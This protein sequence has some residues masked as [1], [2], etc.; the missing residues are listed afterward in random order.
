[1][2]SWIIS[3]IADYFLILKMHIKPLINYVQEPTKIRSITTPLVKNAR[4]LE[5]EWTCKLQTPP[6]SIHN[7]LLIHPI[8]W[9]Y[10]THSSW[11]A[12][13][14]QNDRQEVTMEK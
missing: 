4:I 14:L 13:Q 11:C 1:M 2:P 6:V 12:T 10:Y 8:I 9:V 5:D 3:V 7:F